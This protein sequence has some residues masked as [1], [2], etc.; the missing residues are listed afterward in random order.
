MSDKQAHYQEVNAEVGRVSQRLQRAET[1][2]GTAKE[3]LDQSQEKIQSLSRR[4]QQSESLPQ[5]PKSRGE[6]EVDTVSASI[7]E[8]PHKVCDSQAL[9]P[10]QSSQPAQGRDLSVTCESGAGDMETK[11]SERVTELEKEVCVCVCV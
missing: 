11:L 1:E 8:S 10:G 4:L 9:R 5:T 6:A 7:P 3:A 2:L